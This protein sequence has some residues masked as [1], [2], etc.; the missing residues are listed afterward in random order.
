MTHLPLRLV[1]F[2]IVGALV[3]VSSS[4]CS[5]DPDPASPPITGVNDVKKA[6]E[7]RAAWTKG[8][9]TACSDCTALAISPPCD[10]RKGDGY[11]GLCYDQDRAKVN[12]PQ[13]DGVDACIFKCAADCA[14][15]DACLAGK[16]ACRKLAAADQGCIAQVCDT[17]CK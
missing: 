13:C 15:A 6:C 3:A 17:H 12:E 9:T 14:C 5:S 2:G 7:I 16:D 8:T 4:A 1:T 11:S 10:C